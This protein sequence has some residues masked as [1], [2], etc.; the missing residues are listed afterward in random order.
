MRKFYS[1][2]GEGFRYS[3]D[4]RMLTGET[5]G[6]LTSSGQW[7]GIFCDWFSEHIWLSLVGPEM[8]GETAGKKKKIGLFCS[9]ELIATAT[10]VVVWLPRLVAAEVWVRVLLSYKVQ[11]RS[12]C[13]F[14]LSFH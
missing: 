9:S 1:E 12:V 2:K 8:E 11:P 5:G 3:S 14:S 4:W 10:E 13:I 7:G 6:G